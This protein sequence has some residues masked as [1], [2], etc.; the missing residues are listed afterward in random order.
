MGAKVSE[1][2]NKQSFV[3]AFEEAIGGLNTN[4]NRDKDSFAT[5]LLALKINDFC[6][7][8]KM[9]LLDY[10]QDIVFKKYGYWIGKTKSYLIKK[11]D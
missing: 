5:S 7:K 11:I 6:L 3:V 2:D 10:L 8:K 4:V 9:D 1:L